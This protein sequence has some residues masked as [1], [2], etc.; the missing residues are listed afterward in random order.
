MTAH[1]FKGNGVN[2]LNGCCE[3]ALE[4]IKS[5]IDKL[6][7]C[8]I[9][10]LFFILFL[11]IGIIKFIVICC[12]VYKYKEFYN[13]KD[14]CKERAKKVLIDSC[15]V[16]KSKMCFLVK[17]FFYYILWRNIILNLLLFLIIVLTVIFFYDKL[18]GPFIG[19]LLTINI[20]NYFNYY[21]HQSN[22]NSNKKS[23]FADLRE[24]IKEY[25]GNYLT[26]DYFPV[27]TSNRDEHKRIGEPF[28]KYIDHLDILLDK[29]KDYFNDIIDRDNVLYKRQMKK[30]LYFLYGY[31]DRIY[32]NINT[33]I[34]LFPEN[35]KNIQ[36]LTD[37]KNKYNRQIEIGERTLREK[38]LRIFL[39]NVIGFI[40]ILIE[41]DKYINDVWY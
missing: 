16:M 36:M 21:S 22:F 20:I 38:D 34:I 29:Y 23:I 5:N 2:N 1:N 37:M 13:N 8:F 17:S 18:F 41:V 9:I 3:E 26:D 19:A 14:N 6:I 27:H 28:L 7:V 39:K 24:F 12:N 11:I 15:N 40:E 35:Y 25:T 33:A 10:L 32:E 4:L 30:Y 31:R